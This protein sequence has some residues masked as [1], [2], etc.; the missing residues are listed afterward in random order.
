MRFFEI[1]S[2]FFVLGAFSLAEEEIKSEEGVLVLTK[3]NFEQATTEN[4]FI[5]VEFY[6]PWCGHCKAL[7]PEYEKA[8]QTLKEKESAIKL[9][10]V[11]AT[12]QNELAEKFGIRGYPTL[13]F[14]RNGS[15]IDYSG[16]RQADD[17]VNWLLKKTGP[18]ATALP[19][20]EDAKKFLEEPNVAVV[21]FFKD[22]SGDL[23]KAFLAVASGIDDIPFAITDSDDVF[24]QYEVKDGTVVLFKKFDEG[25]VAYE[26]EANESNLKKFIQSNSLPLLVEFNH[27]TAQKIFGGEIK[28]HLLLFLKKGEESFETVSEAAR[29]VAK[30]FREQVLF[31]T[32]D[33]NEED[34]QRI[35]EFFGMK[36]DEAPAAR[37]IKLEEDMAKYK[38]E[39]AELTAENLQKF[40]QDFLD[41]KLKQHLL[42]Q[43]IP[44][45]WDKQPVKVLVAENFNA[46]AFDTNKDVLVEFYAP[47][48]GH[49]KQLAPI[50]DTVGEH[51]KDNENVVIAK[52]DATA[53]ELETIKV[54]SY[55]TLKMFK[56]ETN[57]IV[58]YD[59]PRT[60]DGLVKFVESGGQ[61]EYP[62]E[63]SESE[64][65]DGK[66]SKDEL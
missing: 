33:T 38:P 3:D 2:L 30:P 65:S 42:S 25:Q 9:G 55:P 48:C 26:G 36:A 66:P 23:A 6:A 34:H 56:K 15:P 14:F 35:L 4:E 63:A 54:T 27:E 57:E 64:D 43:E 45:D 41:G 58:N 49:C 61:T 22:Q 32:I 19:T 44:E 62:E 17:I 24:N 13:K 59:G 50:Y 20:V 21:G 39:S 46:V 5:L 18:P 16:G 11:D 47:W 53:N 8:A 60:F 12:E 40:V 52:M 1:F 10:K 31:V 28:S 51:F 7:A 37:L 29:S